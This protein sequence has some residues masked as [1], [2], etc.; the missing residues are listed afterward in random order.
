MKLIDKG[1]TFEIFLDN[2]QENFEFYLEI[3]LSSNK[4]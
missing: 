1:S 2:I 4:I 3:H